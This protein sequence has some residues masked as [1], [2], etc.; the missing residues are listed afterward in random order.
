MLLFQI[1]LVKYLLTRDPGWLVQQSCGLLESNDHPTPHHSLLVFSQSGPDDECYIS[2]AMTIAVS[3]SILHIQNRSTYETETETEEGNVLFS[4][5]FKTFL[6]SY[7]VVS[8]RGN[9][10]P[11]LHGLRFISISK[12]HTHTH[13]NTHTHTHTHTLSH[14]QDITYTAFVT[15]VVVHRLEREMFQ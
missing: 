15:P 6:F 9:P 14:R 11:P 5:A 8:E 10:L 3:E 1:A 4:D 12:E 13:T 2:N 7:I